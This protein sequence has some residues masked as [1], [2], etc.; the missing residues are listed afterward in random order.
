MENKK[1][2]KYSKIEIAKFQNAKKTKC[3]N[4]H[5]LPKKKNNKRLCLICCRLRSNKSHAKKS[6]ETKKPKSKFDFFN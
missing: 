3:L 1:M 2:I 4:G 6:K 5:T